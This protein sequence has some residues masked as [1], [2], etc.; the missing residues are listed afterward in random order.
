MT[1]CN[2]K[3]TNIC[4]GLEIL[5]LQQL[6]YIVLEP[7][8]WFASFDPNPPLQIDK[9]YKSQHVGGN[10]CCTMHTWV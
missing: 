3:A 5:F 7:F 1:K 10:A 9:A 6:L 2:G 8:W 4:K